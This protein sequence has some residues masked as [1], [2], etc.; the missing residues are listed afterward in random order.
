MRTVRNLLVAAGVVA[1]LAA[2]VLPAHAIPPGPTI[3]ATVSGR[4]NVF[5]GLCADGRARSVFTDVN[6]TG[7][8]TNGNN[9]FA[10]TVAVQD[11]PVC[12]D[13]I[14]GANQ[15][16]ATGTL[17]PGAAPTYSSISAVVGTSVSGTLTSLAFTNLGV[18]SL[19]TAINTNFSVNGGANSGNVL[20]RAVVIALPVQTIA[21][22]AGVAAVCENPSVRDI[23]S[24][25]IVA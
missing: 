16:L 2:A 22:E 4:V 11:V 9:R 13:P 23:V 6:I 21:C 14:V 20:G 7:A 18:V 15:L 12:L 8:F 1:M 5:G 25:T 19:V 10:G 3:A 17:Q 24:A